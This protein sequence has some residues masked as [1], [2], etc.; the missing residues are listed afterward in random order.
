[1]KKIVKRGCGAQRCE[2][3]NVTFNADL[4][5]KGRKLTNKQQ[6][7]ELGFVRDQFV[8]ILPFS[9]YD[10]NSK[11]QSSE[12]SYAAQMILKCPSCA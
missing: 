7:H 10:L 9:E 6:Q 12:A 3:E 11:I 1:M 4:K 8:N 5:K 2:K